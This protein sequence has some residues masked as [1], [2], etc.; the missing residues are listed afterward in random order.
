MHTVRPAP[1]ISPALPDRFFNAPVRFRAS[2]GVFAGTLLGAVTGVGERGGEGAFCPPQRRRRP[3]TMNA[4]H[5]II[6]FVVHCTS[7]DI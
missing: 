5:A 7:T 2:P 3:G 4:I 6:I 1:Q